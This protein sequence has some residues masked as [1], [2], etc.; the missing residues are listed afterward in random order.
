[1]FPYIYCNFTYPGLIRGNVVYTNPCCV[2]TLVDALFHMTH[3]HK[4]MYAE[5]YVHKWYILSVIY[6]TFTYPGLIHTKMLGTSDTLLPTHEDVVCTQIHVVYVCVSYIYFRK[7]ARAPFTLSTFF[8]K[9]TQ[10]KTKQTKK[11]FWVFLCHDFFGWFRKK[12]EKQG[13]THSDTVI[14]DRSFFF[15]SFGKKRASEEF[16]TQL[17]IM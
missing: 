14:T 10:K 11:V 12:T 13:E 5:T 8:P 16:I 4:P 2:Y 17:Y 1:M 15:T 7:R 6:C 9:L 3:V